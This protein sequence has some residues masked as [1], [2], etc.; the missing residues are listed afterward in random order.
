MSNYT[1]RAQ[2]LIEQI[3]SGKASEGEIENFIAEV[4]SEMKN[5]PH[6]GKELGPL[7]PR[8]NKALSSRV[9]IPHFDW[10]K[11]NNGWLAV[12]HKPGGKISFEGMSKAGVTAVLTL[13]QENEGSQVI[14]QAL[15]RVG[16]EWLWFPFSAV[17]PEDRET[18]KAQFS[19]MEALLEKE[20]KIYIHCSAGIHRTGMVTY[21]FLR[22]LGQGPE[23]AMDNLAKM[24]QL[25]AEGFTPERLHWGEQF[26]T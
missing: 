17:R 26:G 22:F 19:K 10:V 25:T 13:L 15:R 18:T 11:I 2:G 23:E 9:E 14:G 20:A 8:I 24:R 1:T 3:N 12:G 16:I 5:S 7:I 21:A 4:K 6:L